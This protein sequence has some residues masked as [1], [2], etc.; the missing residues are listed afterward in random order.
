MFLLLTQLVQAVPLQMTQQ[1]RVLDSSG[2]P[3]E[4]LHSFYFRIFDQEVG[5]TMLWEDLYV[6]QV[7]NG[8]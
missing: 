1:G 2:A 3:Y 7:T 5:G 8:Y 6:V 4:G